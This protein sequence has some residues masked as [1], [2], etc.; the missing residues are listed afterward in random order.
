MER[1]T[2]VFN[3]HWRRLIQQDNVVGVGLGYKET[4][5]RLTDRM[6]MVVLVRQK[7]PE[8]QLSRA[9]LIPP[10][11]LSVETDIIEVGELVALSR[12]QKHRPAMPGISIGH[13]RITAGTL[14]AIVKDA[15]TAQVL[16]LSNNHVLANTSNALDGRARPGDPIL[17]PGPHDGGGR[18][19]LIAR[20]ERFVPI[21]TLRMAPTCSV[22]RSVENATNAVL[23][24]IHSA[25][26][27]RF[28]KKMEKEN[29]VDAAVARPITND[30]VTPEIMDIGVVTETAVA[31]PGMVVKKSGR[32]SG[33]TTGVVRAVNASVKILMGD[34]GEAIFIEQIVTTPMAQPGD[35]GSLVVD[36]NNRAVGLLS[37]GS[38]QATVCNS[39]QNVFRL[40]DIRL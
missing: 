17:Q 2:S 13:Y 37:A 20:L 38:Q 18:D 26:N 15:K 33:L 27:V 6:S 21:I 29:L 39:I 36:S 30:L 3:H 9:E 8:A 22:A 23:R 7:L 10:T 35:S 40:L 16:I 14:G 28:Y 5:G 24:R 34:L 1:L 19:D 32:T 12:V 25:Y 4:K 11:I 31:S